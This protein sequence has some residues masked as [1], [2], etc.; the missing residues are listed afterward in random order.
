VT[1]SAGIQSTQHFSPSIFL[2]TEEIDLVGVEQRC[3]NFRGGAG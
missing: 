1:G 2:I 3:G